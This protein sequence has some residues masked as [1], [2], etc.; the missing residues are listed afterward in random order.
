M[1]I[2]RI[3]SREGGEWLVARISYVRIAMLV[4]GRRLSRYSPGSGALVPRSL[5]AEVDE[6]VM[7]CPVALE[8]S[9]VGARQFAGQWRVMNLCSVENT[10]M[11][12]DQFPS[13]S[14][15]SRVRL[16]GY[17]PAPPRQCSWARIGSRGT[18]I[19]RSCDYRGGW[20]W[21]KA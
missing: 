10:L 13:S 14:L 18:S 20:T 8:P 19:G 3:R 6:A 11:R 4:R 17:V 7:P 16:A 15:A 9:A 21:E 2:G 5:L 12:A 1:R